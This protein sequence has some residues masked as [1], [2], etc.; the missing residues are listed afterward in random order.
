MPA[1]LNGLRIQVVGG[2]DVAAGLL[3]DAGV[4]QA[5]GQQIVTG[6]AKS[7][8]DLIR[9]LANTG[10]HAPGD[11]HI[12]GTGPGPNRATGD[13][14][15]SWRYSSRVAGYRGIAS[16]Q[17]YTEAPQ[18]NRLEYGFVGAD[19]LGRNYRQRPFPHVQPAMA[20]V[21]PRL[22]ARFDVLV[23]ALATGTQNPTGS[24]V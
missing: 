19:S 9:R 24:L 17:V 3:V 23:T 15:R 13:Y 10:Q 20:V 2:E 1:T 5:A 16:A 12:P 4:V 14:I 21:T 8:R 6:E 11:P 22:H 7:L 18:A